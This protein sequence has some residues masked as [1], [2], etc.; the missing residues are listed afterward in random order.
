MS[1]WA[2]TEIFQRVSGTRPEKELITREPIS[3]KIEVNP[4]PICVIF[5]KR[6]KNFELG[7]HPLKDLEQPL[8]PTDLC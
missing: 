2:T 7:T 6:V 5:Y 3:L 1:A 4:L 8:Y